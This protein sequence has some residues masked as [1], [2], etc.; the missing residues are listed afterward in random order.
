MEILERARVFIE[1]KLPFDPNYCIKPKAPSEMSIKELK[2]AI[3]SNNLASKAVGFNEK[4]EFV[5]LLEEF[6]ASK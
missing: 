6:Y 2:A 3:R 1:Q 5:K 4:H